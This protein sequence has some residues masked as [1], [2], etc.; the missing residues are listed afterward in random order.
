MESHDSFE[1][2]IAANRQI[3]SVSNTL[4]D[5]RIGCDR[6]KTGPSQGVKTSLLCCDGTRLGI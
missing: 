1:P 3:G 5:D 2:L 4:P 6:E